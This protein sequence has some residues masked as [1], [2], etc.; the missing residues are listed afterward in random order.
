[1]I[2]E[3]A[4]NFL[5]PLSSVG[6]SGTAV[7]GRINGQCNDIDSSYYSF[8]NLSKPEIC[9]YKSI[10]RN[11][12]NLDNCDYFQSSTSQ[13]F[14]S[15][16][17]I[18]DIQTI[19]DSGI[20]CSITDEIKMDIKSTITEPGFI[21][22][23]S[24]FLTQIATSNSSNSSCEVGVLTPFH[25]VCIP[26][27]PIRAYLIRLAQNFGCS[28]ECFVLAI[29]YIGRIVKYNRNFTI[30]LLNVHRV[31]VT[32]LILAAKFFDDIYYSNAFYAKI[33]GVGTRELNSLEIHFLRL[34][35]FQLFVTEHEYEIYKRCIINSILPHSTMPSVPMSIFNKQVTD[36]LGSNIRPKDMSF[37]G[38][39]KRMSLQNSSPYNY[40]YSTIH[41][42]LSHGNKAE[43]RDIKSMLIGEYPLNS[44]PRSIGNLH[45]QKLNYNFN[46]NTELSTKCDFCSNQTYEIIN[47]ELAPFSQCAKNCYGVFSEKWISKQFNFNNSSCFH[48]Q[49]QEEFDANRLRDLVKDYRFSRKVDAI[50]TAHGSNIGNDLSAGL[51]HSDTFFND[52]YSHIQTN[53]FERVY[54]SNLKTEIQSSNLSQR[55]NERSK[56]QAPSM[57]SDYKSVINLNSNSYSNNLGYYGSMNASNINV[58]ST[59]N[60]ITSSAVTLVNPTVNHYG[61]HIFMNPY[62]IRCTT[63][64]DRRLL[65]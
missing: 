63:G 26:P 13:P 49:I 55:R 31:I 6:S 48:H 14:N 34:I 20:C 1:M 52:R 25:S 51:K 41:N 32:A 50:S 24:S 44:Q 15:Q 64:I 7:S 8:S 47:S 40:N 45:A 36:E 37:I 54:N 42:S 28:N 11:N 33:S 59:T 3:Y 5:F 57:H 60:V 21:V 58:L 17:S 61:Q 39:R 9:T 62:N 65:V 23:L 30:T 56:V 19:R 18:H 53:D 43:S 12:D 16:A 35:G 38:E 29:I 10:L 2:D 22:A 27:I 46:S 4:Y